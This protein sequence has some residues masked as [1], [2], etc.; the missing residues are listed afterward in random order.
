[1]REPGTTTVA[2]GVLL[3]IAKLT[4]LKVSGVHSMGMA[5]RMSQD[6]KSAEGVHVRVIE[7]VVDMDLY[8]V[9]EKGINVRQVSRS[10]QDNVAR[11][12]SDMVGMVAGRIN[13]HIEDI[14]FPPE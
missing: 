6:G 1:M 13:I 2:T 14:Y 3:E 12:I 8:L 4:A 11:A 10:V 5:P 7:N 9:L